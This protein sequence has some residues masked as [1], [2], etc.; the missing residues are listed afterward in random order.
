[1]DSD[2]TSYA[3]GSAQY[4]FVVNDLQSAA[5]NPNINWIIVNIH[6][7][8]Y[9]SS[10]S[11]AINDDVAEIY[12][13]LFD[14]YGVDLVLAGHDH[15]YHRTYPIKYNPSNPPNPIVTSTNTNDYADP[16]GAIFA[17]VGTGG[18]N[19]APIDGSRPL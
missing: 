12:H 15:K 13:P 18:I 7:W 14:Q 6:Q 1:M 4:N 17:V 3:S 8:I 9:R 19:L 11:N 16:Q 10:S 2:R 5:Q